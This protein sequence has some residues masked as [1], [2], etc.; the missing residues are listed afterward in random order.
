MGCMQDAFA[1]PNPCTGYLY[2]GA[3]AAA[4]GLVSVLAPSEAG[5]LALL[6]HYRDTLRYRGATARGET[7]RL[8]RFVRSA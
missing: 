8:T 6:A 4:A 7:L 5:G 3:R 2:I 1:F